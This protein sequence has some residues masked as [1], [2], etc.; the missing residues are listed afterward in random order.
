MSHSCDFNHKVHTH[1]VVETLTSGKKISL[2]AVYIH[3]RTKCGKEQLPPIDSLVL[4]AC[5]ICF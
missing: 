4:F 2:C 5:L 1:L 3:Y